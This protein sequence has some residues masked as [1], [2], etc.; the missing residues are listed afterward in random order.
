LAYNTPSLGLLLSLVP[1][2]NTREIVTAI[3]EESLA[4]YN[5]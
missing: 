3:Y 1:G 4:P 2:E 5:S